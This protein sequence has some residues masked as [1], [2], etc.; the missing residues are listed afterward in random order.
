MRQKTILDWQ[1]LTTASFWVPARL[2]PKRHIRVTGKILAMALL[3]LVSI[4]PTRAAIVTNTYQVTASGFSAL[5]GSTAAPP[6]DPVQLAFTISFDNS[7]PITNSTSNITLIALNM[8]NED[9]L[10]FSYANLGGDSLQVGDSAFAGLIV[11]GHANFELLIENISTTPQFGELFYT[12]KTPAKDAGDVFGTGTGT[13]IVGPPWAHLAFPMVGVTRNQTVRLNVV[14]GPVP[15]P[16]PGPCL[17][18]L[19]IYDAADNLV[20]SRSVSPPGSV[21]FDYDPRVAGVANGQPG[22][23]EELRPEVILM[24]TS[25]S[26]AACQGQATAEVYGDV[27]KSTSIITPGLIPPGAN[28]L[29]AVQ[30]GPVGLGL[31]QTVRLNVVAYPPDSCAGILS[32]TDLNGNPLVTP[33]QVN[34]TAG[35]ATYIDLPGANVLPKLGQH[36]EVL[37]SFVP[38]PGAVTGLCIPSVEVY[39]QLTGRTQAILQNLGSAQVATGPVS[40]A[41]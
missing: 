29:P 23:R 12:V 8:P 3:A 36:G 31:L 22:E 41:F 24:P 13:V 25:P 28:Q 39:D 34:L 37:A 4:S 26:S 33:N 14:E 1:A 38:A 9:P 16:G 7:A 5:H 21:S 20:A 2:Q 18:Q 32:I 6:V 40:G 35:Q 17:A 30:I 10:I 27:E 11:T 19:N 15:V